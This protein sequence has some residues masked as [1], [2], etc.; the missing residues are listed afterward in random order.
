MPPAAVREPHVND[1]DYARAS[2]EGG[3]RERTSERSDTGCSSHR[4]AWRRITTTATVGTTS[5]SAVRRTGGS[6]AETAGRKAANRPT[7]MRTPATV[8]RLRIVTTP[9]L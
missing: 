1:G 2:L 4:M 8:L 9:Y 6:S 3:P 5:Q 7:A